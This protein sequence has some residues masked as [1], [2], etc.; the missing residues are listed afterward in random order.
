MVVD[1][2]I[3]FGYE[4]TFR[5]GNGMS[6]CPPVR[7]DD[8]SLRLNALIVLDVSSFCS[9]EQTSPPVELCS[10]GRTT[11]ASSNKGEGSIAE[12]KWHGTR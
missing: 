5:V 3:P 8:S 10:F 7:S 2:I 6:H 12:T 9:S 1:S 4:L 11:V